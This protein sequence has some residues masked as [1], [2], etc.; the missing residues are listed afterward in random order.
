MKDSLVKSIADA[1]LYEGYLLYP[2]RPSAVKNQQRWNFGAL[3]PESYSLAQAGTESW[4]MQTQVLIEA[5]P[6]TKLNVAVRFLHVLNREVAQAAAD[7]HS[8]ICEC[9]HRELESFGGIHLGVVP[10]LEVNGRLFQP[11]Q[12]AVEREVCLPQLELGESAID[13]TSH[14]FS[15]PASETFE[16]LSDDS[17]REVVGALIR[18]QETIDGVVEIR[19]ERCELRSS[20]DE[21]SPNTSEPHSGKNSKANQLRKIT[22]QIRNLTPFEDA[23]KL[24]RDDS[25]MRSFVS[26]HTILTV[27]S[28]E[29][30]SLLDPPEKFSEAAAG[31]SNVGTFP[32]L[33][34]EEGTRD[35]MLSSPIILYDYPQIAPESPGS[36]FDG[37]E[38]DEI[39]TLRIMT[40]TDEEKREMRNADDRARQ[41]LER[42]E[43]L[44]VELFM[45][46]HGAMKGVKRKS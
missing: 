44:P 40:L 30:V 13:N 34:G 10:V 9:G 7:C 35:C 42:T 28:G 17:I 24:T 4:A 33:V 18:R 38:I 14:L 19:V 36:L 37:T 43:S 16:P 23:G 45:K 6:N 39:L 26:T 5:S 12:E 46:M 29:F 32:V 41:I 27:E 22:V 8:P 15:F 25:L 3:C 2:Y 11:L 31:C 1:V 21:E 20:A